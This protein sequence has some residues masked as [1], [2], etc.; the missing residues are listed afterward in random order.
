MGMR[1]RV[2]LPE[3]GLNLDDAGADLVDN[4][5]GAD[6]VAGNLRRAPGQARPGQ[7]PGYRRTSAPQRA[8]RAAAMASCTVCASSDV[9]VRSAAR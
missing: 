7:P 3:V 8:R 4:Q 5:Q 2:G 6:Q 1:R 9:S